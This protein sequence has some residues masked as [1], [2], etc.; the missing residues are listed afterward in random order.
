[1]VTTIPYSQF[2]K[3]SPH[4]INDVDAQIILSE[5][6][7]A[8]RICTDPEHETKSEYHKSI[9]TSTIEKFGNDVKLS[10]DLVKANDNFS[11]FKLLFLSLNDL[12]VNH[13]YKNQDT[14][15]L[16]F[17]NDELKGYYTVTVIEN[18]NNNKKDKYLITPCTT[19]TSWEPVSISVLEY[20]APQLLEKYGEI[21]TYIHPAGYNNRFS[22]MGFEILFEKDG[23]YI[24]ELTK[25]NFVNTLE[26]EK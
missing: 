18:D 15:Y 7:D 11:W 4:L 10:L 5:L 8:F 19:K 25:E 23:G 22:K 16:V 14:S 26:G 17:K 9:Y 13:I 20:V 6:I 12:I 3:C 24:V 21:Y 1:M 2:K